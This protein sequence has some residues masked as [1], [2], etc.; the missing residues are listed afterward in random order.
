MTE[1]NLKCHFQMVQAI[2]NDGSVEFTVHEA[3]STEAGELYMV[4][5]VPVYIVGDSK[6]EISELTSMVEKDIETY[7]V[8]NIETLQAKFDIYQEYTGPL[9]FMEPDYTKEEALNVEE[10]LIDEDYHDS[11]GNILD[12]VEFMNRKK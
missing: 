7:G 3:F 9:D 1:L 4:A 5:P 2:N 8:V 6:E 11:D 12:L 10:E